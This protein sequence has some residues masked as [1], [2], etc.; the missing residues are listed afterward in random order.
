MEDKLCP[1]CAETIKA[2][3]I[4]C[5]F[6]G[7]D[8]TAG[9]AP[10]RGVRQPEPPP[11]KKNQQ[12]KEGVGALI[13]VVLIVVGIVKCDSNDNSTSPPVANNVAAPTRSYTS[14][15]D[16]TA[17]PAAPVQIPPD[18]AEFIAAVQQSQ[19]DA[20]GDANDM[21]RGGHKATRDKKICELLSSLAVAD[22]IG[23]VKTVDSNS[24]GKGVLA[25][26][27][28]NTN[29]STLTTD[30]NS[31]SDSLHH[32]LIEPGTPLFAAASA[33]KPGQTVR[34][35]GSFI[36]GTEGECI[37]EQSLTLNG[38]LMDPD[39]TFQFTSVST[40]LSAPAR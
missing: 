40:D 33:M 35:S 30:N 4:K 15:P 26:A 18:E 8:L 5:R 9:A 38:K 34:F 37:D 13:V 14:N 1:F 29:S 23:N 7:S 6:C 11:P 31:F 22:W 28:V 27:L 19:Q 24:D 16:E 3:A 21:Q 10:M 12:L 25:V 2:A 17:T 32:T 36:R 20:R 39:F